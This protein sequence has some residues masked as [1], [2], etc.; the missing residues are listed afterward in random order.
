M[1]KVKRQKFFYL[2]IVGVVWSIVMTPLHEFGHWVVGSA[3]GGQGIGITFSGLF[4]GG[5][6]H[7]ASAFPNMWLSHIAGGLFAGSIMFLL[8]L[9][10]ALTPTKWDEPELFVL[11]VLGGGQIGY[12]LAEATLGTGWFIPLSILGIFV[13]VLIPL[14]WRLLK[15]FDWLFD[16]NQI[17][18]LGVK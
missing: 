5:L 12:G 7:W 3:L 4:G 10:A 15:L 14:S 8:A 6:C 9:K 11:T 2:I 13:G 18:S 16:D 17:Y 1:T